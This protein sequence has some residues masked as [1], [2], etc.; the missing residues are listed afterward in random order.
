MKFCHVLVLMLF[1]IAAP[2][3]AQD[4]PVCPAQVMLALARSGSACFQL[5]RNQACFGNGTVEGGF[6]ATDHAAWSKPGDIVGVG[7]LKA[8]RVKPIEKGISVATLFTQ[9][10]LSDAEERRIVF[11]LFG[12][13]V[14]ENL[15]PPLPELVIAATGALNIRHTPETKG[16]I[17]NKIAINKALIAN[18][19][20]EDGV[21]L[22]V[23]IPNTNDLG[24]VSR[25]VIRADGDINALAVV[26]IDTPVY[27]PFQVFNVKTTSNP[28]CDG[29]LDSGLLLQAPT[30]ADTR[31]TM[32]GVDLRLA[33]TLF[34]QVQGDSLVVNV[35]DGEAELS[36]NGAAEFVPAGARTHIPLDATT[37]MA[38]DA[39]ARAEP[40]ANAD[41]VALPTGNLPYRLTIAAALTQEQIDQALAAHAAIVEATPEPE[42]T[43]A[44]DTGCKR[45]VKRTT[46]LWGG[47]GL[48][49]EAVN[50]LAPGTPVDPVLQT[51]DADGEVWW[52]LRSSN[53][54]QAD[55]VEQSGECADI[56]VTDVIPAPSNNQLSL[57]TCETSNGPLRVGQYVVIQ[58]IPPPWDNYGEARDA[59]SIDPGR[60]TIDNDLYYAYASEPSRL[61]TVGERYLRQFYIMWIATAGTHRIVGDRL[62][63]T[64]ICTVT[65][66]VG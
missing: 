10:N 23:K 58:F 18:G 46:T 59:V 62:H 44:L 50:Q 19:R 16:D 12:D 43:Q 31:L 7:A 27:R 25:D 39:P 35:L 22:R 32:N 54:V 11:M 26:G 65:V 61:G 57:E 2:V 17:V 52:Q 55:V 66:P 6:F 15:V 3:A 20:T 5:E 45:I 1:L 14:L 21:W 40:Y 9:A 33:S 63:Y 37:L 4:A 64:P 47:P 60:I 38:S 34:V 48:F 42:A 30:V 51:T 28:L 36:V 24:W 41:F 56:P 8:V 49:Y 29:K 13:A 53:W